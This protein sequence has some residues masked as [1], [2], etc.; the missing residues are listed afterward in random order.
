TE[1]VS[2]KDEGDY[3]V[4]LILFPS[5]EEEEE[6]LGETDIEVVDPLEE[7]S[8]VNYII[9]G[10]FFIFAIGLSVFAYLKYKRFLV[11]IKKDIEETMQ[12]KEVVAESKKVLDFIKQQGGRTTQ[13]EIRDKFPS[14]EA[15]IS[16]IISELEHK[17]IIKKIKKGRGNIIVLK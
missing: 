17:G 14:S 8:Y 3:V 1:S 12:S 5:F 13:K 10:V 2:I 16:L 11:K 9:G 6:L 7:V 4:D 15:K